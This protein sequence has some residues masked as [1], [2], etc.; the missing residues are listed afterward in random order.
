MKELPVI[1][2]LCPWLAQSTAPTSRP[3]YAGIFDSGS[4]IWFMVF[5]IV[6]MWVFMLRGK[7]KQDRAKTDLLANLKKGDRIRTIGGILGTVVEARE[8]EVVV[9]VDETSNAKMRFV[10]SAIYAVIN[11]DK[12]KTG[13]K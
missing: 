11:S 2:S 13:E 3:P 6:A 7:R 5:I 4:S 12:D 8:D 9:K 1:P 10:R